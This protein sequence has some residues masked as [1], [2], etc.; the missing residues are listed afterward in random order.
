MKTLKLLFLILSLLVSGAVCMPVWALNGPSVGTIVNVDSVSVNVY[1]GTVTYGSETALYVYVPVYL[2]RSN[3]RYGDAVT[4]LAQ[5]IYAKI[6]AAVA[7]EYAAI[8]P[9]SAYLSTPMNGFL[10]Y[11]AKGEFV[12]LDAEE[13]AAAF[14]DILAQGDWSD[15]ANAAAY[16][17]P[18]K[19]A[20]GE[21]QSSTGTEADYSY[22]FSTDVSIEYL[23]IDDVLTPVSTQILNYLNS[24]IIPVNQTLTVKTD[25]GID[26]PQA[27]RLKAWVENGVLHVSG[28]AAGKPCKVY[29]AAGTLIAS[30]NPSKE[31]EKI[32]L[33][34]RGVYVV[35]SGTETI[36]VVY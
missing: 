30:S 21:P 5:L 17:F 11:A 26:V 22:L 28:L 20:A 19:V 15:I 2:D 9:D 16:F 24:S 13:G 29:S 14:A 31:E 1:T 3:S 8:M 7:P 36:K 10:I 6:V 27:D 32:S 18:G 12:T 23:Y 4:D 25:I 33:P 35:V 34:G